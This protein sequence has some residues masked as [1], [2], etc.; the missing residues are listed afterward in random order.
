MVSREALCTAFNQSI[1]KTTECQDCYKCVRSCPVKAIRVRDGH[2]SVE[3]HTCIYCGTC[4]AVC[5]NSAKR[6]RNDLPR[7]RRLIGDGTAV[8]ASLAPSFVAEFPEYS[9]HQVIQAIEA[10]GF[11]EVTETA[12]GA[13]YVSREVERWFGEGGR[14][15][16]ISTA[17]PAVVDLVTKYYPEL[18]ANLSDTRLSIDGARR[19]DTRTDTTGGIDRLYRAVHRQEV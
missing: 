15:V 3:G 2:A 16:R 1:P 18:T 11:A 10:L 17:C 5:P 6:V 9:P 7:V 12:I 13:E 14:G 4:V 8:Y 19:N